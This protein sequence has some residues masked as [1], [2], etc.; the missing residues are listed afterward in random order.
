MSWCYTALDDART[1]V[2]G[3]RPRVVI[4]GSGFAGLFAA[5]KLANADA[6]VIVV[7]KSTHHLF[8]PLLYQVATGILSPGEIAPSTREVLRK[9]KN[10]SVL[11][12]EV[13]DIDLKSRVLT[14]KELGESRYLPYDYLI[15]AAGAGQSYFGHDEFAS[16]APGMKSVDDALELRARIFSCL[17]MAEIAEDNDERNRL[18]T[19]VVVGAGPTGV[20]MAGQIRELTQRTVSGE[21]R[22]INPS[23]ARV[24]LLDAND[25]VL[26]PF[27]DKLSRK[28]QRKLE[29]IGVEIKLGAKVVG[30]D[31]D[32][33][34]VQNSVGDTE[35]IGAGCKVWAAGVEASHL[36]AKIA[37]QTECEID[38][39]GRL[40][41]NDDCTVPGHPE[42]FVVGDM[43]ALNG[44]PGV[45][46]VAIQ[47]GRFAAEEIRAE[48][49]GKKRA[50]IFK[51]RDRG[52]MA[53]ISKFS[54]VVKIGK[55]EIG[56]FIAWVAW[57]FLHLLYIVGF[58]AQISTL[59]HWAIAFVTD[60]R[61]ERVITRQQMVGRLALKQLG[62]DFHPTITGVADPD[63][64]DPTSINRGVD[65]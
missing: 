6:E 28:A 21:Y 14:L 42:V 26:A 8:Q 50:G 2:T 44:L 13:T 64:I 48:L 27:G 24:I 65:E 45:A 40:L 55:F 46:Q 60:H 17:E 33:I 57:L 59:V 49:A 36:G 3:Q 61:A 35:Q 34:T 31:V 51:Y 37:D 7:G 39:A 30:V 53:I 63:S 19:Y 58:K 52:S 62:A 38:R 20:E 23:D 11:L 12:S 43:M 25:R 32:G 22:R 10:A 54:A 41:V 47:S 5:K 15:V 56:G 29:S 18:M 9:Q 16:F 4:I 1:D